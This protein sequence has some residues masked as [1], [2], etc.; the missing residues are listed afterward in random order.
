M[1]IVQTNYLDYI[2]RDGRTV[3]ITRIDVSFQVH[4]KEFKDK[5]KLLVRM[6]N[7][8]EPERE[9]NRRV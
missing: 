1:K 8:E 6:H 7:F 2:K 4:V 3:L 9:T 5:V